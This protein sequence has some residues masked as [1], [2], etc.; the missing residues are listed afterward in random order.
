MMNDRCMMRGLAGTSGRTPMNQPFA[1]NKGKPLVTADAGVTVRKTGVHLGAE[2]AGVDLR[3]L[4]SEP[5]FKAVEAALV[6]HELIV[7]RDQ[8]ISSDNL[9]AFGRRF[10]ELTVH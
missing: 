9:L 6:E 1:F 3:T 7:L 8:D 5:Q 10:G 2:I 4:L